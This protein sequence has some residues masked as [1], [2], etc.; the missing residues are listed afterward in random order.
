MFDFSDQYEIWEGVSSEKLDGH[1]IMQTIKDKSRQEQSLAYYHEL[2]EMH[3][4]LFR[5]VLHKLNTV[6]IVYLPEK[7][8]PP[9]YIVTVWRDPSLV[10]MG[11]V[12]LVPKKSSEE[13][14]KIVNES[15]LAPAIIAIHNNDDNK[16]SQFIWKL[17]KPTES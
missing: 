2:V 12:S 17:I 9:G 13:V 14:M 6:Y 7:E 16:A 15:I 4:R 10:G 3:D 1:V 11:N 5:L 8:C